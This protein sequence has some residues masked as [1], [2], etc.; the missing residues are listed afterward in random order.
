LKNG[1]RILYV[2]M[3]FVLVA[4]IY[5]F[6]LQVSTYRYK[7]EFEKT[8]T[9]YGQAIQS[10]DYDSEYSYGDSAFKAAIDE[11]T[12]AAQ[13]AAFESQFGKLKVVGA[14]QIYIHGQGSPM[15]WTAMVAEVRHYERGELHFTCEFHLEDG[16]WQ[17]FGCKQTE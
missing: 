12:F 7:R 17:L 11:H 4:L 16:R 1:K 9:N 2:I 13:E 6:Q 10:R 14:G 3:A 8:F 5:N 15:H